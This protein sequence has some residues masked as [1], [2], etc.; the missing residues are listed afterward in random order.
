MTEYFENVFIFSMNDEMVHT[1]FA[2]MDQPHKLELR[3][4]PADDILRRD[5][6]RDRAHSSREAQHS[7]SYQSCTL[8]SAEQRTGT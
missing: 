4:K 1:G 3:R 2:S 6:S 7:L 8:A 5:S